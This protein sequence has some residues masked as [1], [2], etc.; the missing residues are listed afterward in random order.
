V[1]GDDLSRHDLVQTLLKSKACH[2]DVL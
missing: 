2:P 1:V